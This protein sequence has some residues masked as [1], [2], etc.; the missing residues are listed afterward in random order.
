MRSSYMYNFLRDSYHKLLLRR[1]DD[2][3]K[4]FSMEGVQCYGVLVSVYDG[5][6]F[7]AVIHANGHL[8]KMT[9][10]PIGYDTPE[11]R[12]P[13]VMENR[14]RHIEKAKEARQKFIE[15]CG[16]MHSYVFL[17]CGKFDKYGRVLVHVSNRRYSRRTIND[18][19]LESGLAQMYHG[20]K[21]AIFELSEEKSA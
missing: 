18:M 4:Q 12:P 21:K 14:E 6:T 16:G 7:R 13:K 19:M 9:F 2:S 1:A 11:M 8:K 5:D 15:L 10:R 17:R 3:V 20:G